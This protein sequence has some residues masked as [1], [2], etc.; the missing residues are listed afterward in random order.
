MMSTGDFVV[1]SYS[2]VRVTIDPDIR[3]GPLGEVL[4]FHPD[5][6]CLCMC[7]CHDKPGIRHVVACCR[8]CAQCGECI[9]YNWFNAHNTRHDNAGHLGV[10]DCDHKWGAA[11][12]H[13]PKRPYR[14]TRTTLN[15]RTCK[16]C[17]RVEVRD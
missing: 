12:E 8:V 11:E 6:E 10:L 9:E 17:K 4:M 3:I 5:P 13:S 7:E 16:K 2:E 15:L 1:I 14:C